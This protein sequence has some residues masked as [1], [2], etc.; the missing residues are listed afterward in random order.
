MSKRG[1]TRE[2]FLEA[3]LSALLGGRECP[4]C[5]LAAETERA[6][7]SWLATT[8]IRDEAT[9]AKLV[10]ARGLCPGHWR[11]VLDRGGD[12]GVSGVSLLS[13]LV[14]A[15]AADLRTNATSRSPACPICE[16]IARRERSTLHMLFAALEEPGKVDTYRSSPGICRP[17]L[18]MAVELA[19]Q[20]S[21]RQVLIDTQ[22]R[23]LEVLV[24]DLRETATNVSARQT[25]T[26]RAI[27]LLVGS[28]AVTGHVDPG[29]FR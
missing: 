19:P 8:N 15:T 4:V 22:L 10:E 26:R 28:N 3:E 20:P 17:H 7:V 23:A 21:T 29:A 12:L 13:R 24:G 25:A 27:A 2:D 9:I 6:I 1:S 18:A 14:E 16:P 5:V 11:A